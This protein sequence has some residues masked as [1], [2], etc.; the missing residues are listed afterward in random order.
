MEEVR[1]GRKEI[2]AYPLQSRGC[3]FAFYSPGDSPSWQRKGRD[4]VPLPFHPNAVS[5]LTPKVLI[6]DLMRSIRIKRDSE[7]VYHH[8]ILHRVEVHDVSRV[9]LLNLLVTVGMSAHHRG[10][11]CCQIHSWVVFYFEILLKMLLVFTL[12][13]RL[14]VCLIPFL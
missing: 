14:P 8:N 3:I 11:K 10:A 9:V 4:K 7:V 2:E 6:K 13:Q 1:R 12:P 5:F